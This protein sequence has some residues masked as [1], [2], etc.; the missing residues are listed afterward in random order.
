MFDHALTD[1]CL[2]P[3]GDGRGKGIR[4]GSDQS[5]QLPLRRPFGLNWS[6]QPMAW[7]K[8]CWAR[9]LPSSVLGLTGQDGWSVYRVCVSAEVQPVTSGSSPCRVRRCVCS[10]LSQPC[11]QAG[12]DKVAPWLRVRLC[13]HRTLEH[14]NQSSP[15]ACRIARDGHTQE[16]DMD[17]S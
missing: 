17:F 3:S 15:G 2:P 9:G 12:G 11:P 6:H 4:L 7:L 8:G 16:Q 1:V 13:W 5:L 10:S 14:A